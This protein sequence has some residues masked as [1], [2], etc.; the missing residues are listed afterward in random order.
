MYV[1]LNLAI[2]ERALDNSLMTAAR[3]LCRSA[4]ATPPGSTQ[5]WMRIASLRK[6]TEEV[7]YEHYR[8]NLVIS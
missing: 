2:Q 5:M 3:K 1:R 8:K 6:I 4:I 7:V